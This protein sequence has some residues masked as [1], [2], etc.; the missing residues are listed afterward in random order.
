MKYLGEKIIECRKIVINNIKYFE[1]WT[2]DKRSIC[3]IYLHMTPFSNLTINFD[4]EIG[5][6]NYNDVYIDCIDT[7][8]ENLGMKMTETLIQNVRRIENIDELRSQAREEIQNIKLK[9]EKY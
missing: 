9:Y 4:Y 1:F 6:K 8:S 2:K 3:C 7:T 5:F